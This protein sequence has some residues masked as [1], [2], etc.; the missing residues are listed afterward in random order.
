[1]II[2]L[3]DADQFA[4]AVGA[5]HATAIRCAAPFAKPKPIADGVTIQRWN[6]VD[7][8]STIDELDSTID[9]VWTGERR[10]DQVFL[11]TDPG[12]AAC[13]RKVPR[14]RAEELPFFP[15]W[16][17]VASLD[18]FVFVESPISERTIVKNPFRIG[19]MFVDQFPS[20]PSRRPG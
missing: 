20:R 19:T 10:R 9:L 2:E 3:M 16:D 11:Q 14:K 13:A 18:S 5:Q 1:M 15:T 17:G 4:P 6:A 7:Q 12:A 8:Q